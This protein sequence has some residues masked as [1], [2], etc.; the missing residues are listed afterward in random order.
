MNDRIVIDDMAAAILNR[1]FETITMWNRLEGR[2]RKKDFD[3]ALKAEIRDPLWM[4]TKQWQMGEFQG[5]DAGSPILA[6]IALATKR[7]EKYKF[8]DNDAKDYNNDIPLEGLVEKL[9]IPFEMDETIFSLDLRI[10]MGRYWLKLINA[11]F[12]ISKEY[13]GEYP[14]EAPSSSESK[15]DA[16]I[17]AHPESWQKFAAAANRRLDGYVFYIHLKNGGDAAENINDLAPGTFN[18]QAEKYMNWV[19]NFFLQ[20]EKSTEGVEETAYIPS[21]LEYQ[22]KCSAPDN[23]KEKVY[24]AKEYYTGRLDWFNLSLN[25]DTKLEVSEES[26]REIESGD[27]GEGESIEDNVFSFIPVSIDYDGMPDTR[28][29]KFED[30]NTYLG[31]IKPDTKD[32][33]KLLLLEFTLLYANDWFLIPQTLP[34]ATITHIRGMMVTNCFG[35]RTWIEPTGKGVDDDWQ[36]WTMFTINRKG[37]SLREADNSIILMPTV[38]K[39][40]E[41]SA[42]EKVAMVR[43]E[44]ANMVWAVETDIQLPSG[45]KKKGI[46]AG[47]ELYTF[48][49]RLVGEPESIDDEEKIANIRYE[50]MNT[51]PENWIPF[52]PVHKDSDNREIQL[53]RASMSRIIPGDTESPAAVKPRAFLLRHGLDEDEKHS[54]FIYEEEIPR[55][56]ISVSKSFQRTRWYGGKVFNWLGIRKQIGRGEGSSNLAFDQIIP[57]LKPK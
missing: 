3:R 51:I 26:R 24:E 18:D 28:W 31:D 52:I 54:Y 11:T 39:I 49:K 45:D 7:L 9:S 5:N 46:E 25:D 44:I 29:W 19:E 35:E 22:F 57:T 17:L 12:D 42:I 10:M 38:P 48:Y 8:A 32:I 36:R 33:S 6:K 53:Q 1:D 2:P 14:I 13:A 43:D 27:E 47:R 34:A 21:R 30:R 4:L 50:I 16:Q 20:P 15:P 40:Q 55:A 56:G 37:K 23:G 41:G